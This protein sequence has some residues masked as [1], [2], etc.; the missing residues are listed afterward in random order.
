M[1]GKTWFG[2]G[3][4]LA[5]IGCADVSYG[6]GELRRFDPCATVRCEAGTTCRAR[7]QR[8]ECVPDQSAGHDAGTISS[9]AA[10]LCVIGSVCE[11]TPSGPRCV[12]LPAECTTDADCHL[13]DNYCG[14][15]YCVALANGESAPSC[16]D[17]V[18]CFAA[19][20]SVSDSVAACVDGQCV[21]NTGSTF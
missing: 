7:G 13:E 2:F 11:E 21:A 16:T 8:A 3:L 18:Q 6:T 1:T 4:A 20:C 12:P 17:P 9:C 15:C 10:V 5:L 14:G 19:P